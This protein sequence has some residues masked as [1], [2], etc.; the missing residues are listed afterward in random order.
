VSGSDFHFKAG[1]LP[2]TGRRRTFAPGVV[3]ALGNTQQPA[4]RR[5]RI[6]LSQ[7]FNSAVSH[8]DSFA[9]QAANFLSRSRSCLTSA[10]S[11][12]VLANSSSRS[13]S[14]FTR[15]AHLLERARPGRLHPV[16]QAPRRYR[17]PP[18]G[19]PAREALSLH[20]LDRLLTKFLRIN[21]SRYLFHLRP[22]FTQG[23][24]I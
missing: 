4:E 1:L 22:P 3:A 9:K 23:Y 11:F 14:G 17:Q 20:Q 16:L 10:S 18:G 15:C 7:G 12:L 19:F 5:R 24:R 2:S 6:M 21:P 13:V 8:R